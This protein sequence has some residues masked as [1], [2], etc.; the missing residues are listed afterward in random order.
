LPQNPVPNFAGV[1]SLFCAT[2]SEFVLK[3]HLTNTVCHFIVLPFFLEVCLVLYFSYFSRSFEN[4]FEVDNKASSLSVFSLYE[5]K[6]R[7]ISYTRD[8]CV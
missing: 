8:P 1:S 4:C 6:D 5:I 7:I 3:D 2:R